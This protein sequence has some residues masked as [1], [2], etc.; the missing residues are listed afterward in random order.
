MIQKKKYAGHKLHSISE[1]VKEFGITSRAIR[2]YEEKGL[3]L[4]ERSKGGRRLFSQKQKVRLKL[5]LRGKR[6]G[7]SLDEIATIIG[8]A[9]RELDPREQTLRALFLA[10]E[11]LPE[12]KSR[13]K[14]LTQ[15]ADDLESL[16]SRLRKGLVKN[17]Q[18]VF[19][20]QG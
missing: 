20:E 4:A 2:F 14:E 17:S 15:L 10:E 8:S 18:A 13:I 16:V 1:L 12:I 9:E 3:L 19:G 7:L 11:K 6:F 5:I